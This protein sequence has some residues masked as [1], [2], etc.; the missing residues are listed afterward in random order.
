MTWVKICGI[1]N[2][3][4]AQ[5]AVEAGADALGFVFYERSPRKVDTESVRKII[6]QLPPNI[7]KVGV[8]V[9]R[10]AAQVRETVGAV[11]LSAVQLH[12]KR[13]LTEIGMSGSV[14]SLFAAKKVIAA[15]PAETFKDGVFFPEPLR[16]LLFAALVDSPKNGVPGGTGAPFDWGE[17]RGM[18]QFLSLSVPV[19]IAGGLNPLNVTEAIRIF[20]PF[21]V[22]VASGTEATPGKKDP[23]KVRAFITAARSARSQ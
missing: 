23:V 2:L 1:T 12:G 18:I 11:G 21:G 4:D 16:R 3:E 22:D 19:I 8:F 7:E 15:F 9:D 6:A 5:I 20:Q 17:A 13:S 14:E 10:E